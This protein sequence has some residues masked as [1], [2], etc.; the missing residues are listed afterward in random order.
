LG[1]WTIDGVQNGGRDI[2]F[3]RDGHNNMILRDNAE[4]TQ[5]YLMRPNNG[6]FRTY[7]SD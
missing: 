2:T 4:N 1:S 3:N 6:G 5:L 7:T